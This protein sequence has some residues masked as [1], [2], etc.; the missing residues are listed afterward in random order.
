MLRP[1]STGTTILFGRFSVP[2]S[3]TAGVAG[4]ASLLALATGCS[5]TGSGEPRQTVIRPNESA[6]PSGGI[7]P[8]KEAEIQ[9]LLQQ[10]EVSIH[11]CYQDALNTRNDRAF[12]G[13]VKVVIALGTDGHAREVRMAGGTLPQS[14]VQGCLV[15][16]IMRFEFPALTQPGEVQSE[17]QFK[18]AY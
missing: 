14:E 8:D 12:A 6:P 4:C 15:E 1:R 7:A 3:L 9:L 11:K 2:F 5:T 10:R 17:F 18:P 13:S 16:T